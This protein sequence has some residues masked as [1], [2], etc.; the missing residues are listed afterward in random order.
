MS[1]RKVKGRSGVFDITVSMGYESGRQNRIR[2]RIDA[3]DEIEA[4]SFE[5]A[6][7]KELEK[8]AR[9][10]MNVSAIAAQYIPWIELHQRETTVHDKKRMLYGSILP[11]FGRMLPAGIMPVLIDRYKR[12]RLDETRRGR[13]HRQI[14]LELCCLSA[15]ISWAA[16]PG[17]GLCNDP[18]PRF[19]KMPYR[20][21]VPETLSPAEAVAV[22][23]SMTPFHR[24]LYYCLYHAGL[25]KSEA[26][27]LRWSDIRF[28]HGVIR[29]EDAK[30]GK[31]RVVPMSGLLTSLLREHRVVIA[32][33]KRFKRLKE[34]GRLDEDLVFPSHR[35]GRQMNDIRWP[36]KQCLELSTGKRRV[37]PHVLRHTFATHLVDDG[38]DLAS[39]RDLLGHES[40]STTQIYTHPALKTKRRA[41]ERTFGTR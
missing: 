9:G 32:E 21:P 35:T 10:T 12:K 31:T 23:E 40:V 27:A 39:L 4:T 29:I 30:G 11:Y 28:E 36:L 3:A 33:T 14:N 37:T 25:R 34:L 19:A 13:I 8:P 16:D 22:I 15:M 41:I 2:R 7:I 6:L 24:A 18:L 1:V 20:R 26:T 17:R 38:L 5:K